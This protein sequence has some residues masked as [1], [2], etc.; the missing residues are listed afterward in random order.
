MDDFKIEGIKIFVDRGARGIVIIEGRQGVVS[1]E[2]IC[3]TCH[4]GSVLDSRSLAWQEGGHPVYVKP[5]DKVHIPKSFPL[6]KYGR[7]FC[8]TCHSAH[9]VDWGKTKQE[10]KLQRTIFLR[11]ENPNSFICR[12]CHRDKVKGNK[13]EK[14]HNHPVDVTSLEIPK[15]IE[16]LGGKVGFKKNQV[17]CE[18]CHKVHGAKGGYK[19]LIKSV[20]NA[21]LCGVCHKDRDVHSMKEAAEKHTHPVN[22]K[23]I[24]ARI[25]ETFQKNGA[26]V[27]RKGEIICLSCH[28]LHNNSANKLL[29]KSNKASSLC[30]ECHPAQKN[31]ILKTKHDLTIKAPEEKNALGQTPAQSGPCG[32]CHLVHKGYAA[33]MWARKPSNDQDAIEK[34]CKSCH[35]KGKVAQKKLTGKISHPV[36]VSI[37]KVDGE[38]DLPLYDAE[39]GA[40]TFN[41]RKGSVTCASCHNTHQWDP[42]QPNNTRDLTEL[43]GNHSNSFLRKRND[44]GTPICYECHIDKSLIEGTDH[45]MMMMAAKHPR[46]HCVQILGMS[47]K[48]EMI[49][50]PAKEVHKLMGKEKGMAT[51]ICGTCHTPHN[52]VYYRL[53]NRE[54]GP[55]ENSGDKLCFTCHAKGRVAEVKLLGEYTHP[56]GVDINRL[57]IEPTTKLPL[58]DDKLNRKS[59]KEGGKVMCTSCHNPHQWDAKVKKKGPGVKVEGDT[60]NSFTRISAQDDKFALCYDCHYDKALIVGTKHDMNVTAPREKNYRNQTVSQSGVC[61]ACHNVHNAIAPWRL[62]NRSLGPGEDNMSKLCNSCHADGRVGQKKQ[63]GQYSHPVGISILGAKADGNI[64]FPTYKDNLYK[65]PKAK[66]MCSSCHDPH[67]WDPGK[68]EKGDFK[69]EEGGFNNSFLR[70]RNENGYGLCIQC[71]EGKDT[72]VETEHDLSVSVPDATNA[73]GDTVAQKGPC[74]QCHRVHNTLEQTR[75]WS[76]PL[77]PGED[78]ISRMCQSC[79][80]DGRVAQK[81]QVGENSHPIMADMRKADGYTSWPLFNIKG[82]RDPNGLVACASCH[83]PHQ[84][85]PSIAKRGPGVNTEGDMNNSFLRKANI[86]SPDFCEEC[87]KEKALVYQTDHDMSITAPESKNLLGQTVAQSGVCSAC[88]VP[89]NAPNKARIFSRAFGPPFIKN[90]NRELGEEVDRGVQYCTSCHSP[91]NPAE[92]KQP[93]VGLHPYGILVGIKNTAWT[94]AKSGFE[95]FR[96]VYKTLTRDLTVK[97]FQIG[98]FRPMYPAYDNNGMIT[99]SGDLVCPTCHNPHVW[100]GDKFERGPGKNVEGWVNN[101]FL[102]TRLLY[103]FCTDCHSYDA[104]YRMKYYHHPRSREKLDPNTI[105]EEMRKRKYLKELQSTE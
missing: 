16:Q 70:A 104:I 31:A 78:G 3:Y 49:Q 45:D 101:S 53:W 44:I 75:L 105:F 59:A 79:H 93:L 22:V 67:R 21:E 50:L 83:D 98:N 88:H 68:K 8:G 13:R 77:G 39:T 66:V 20:E 60:G 62:W 28:K 55:G 57:G 35:E 87:H 38:T 7:I 40:R 63:S 72:L 85:D 30:F 23:P 5:S 100:D 17:I 25:P 12:Q 41:K 37:S 103:D 14:G 91:G 84:W 97:G 29:V 102:R 24:T 99:P 27:G 64:P 71:H 96:Y 10:Q 33:K 86:P 15:E 46:S 74:W 54:L 48:H 76:R 18:S 51:G 26:K 81:K 61:F 47:G 11:F 34:L 92:N 89:H 43:E 82:K 52:A 65:T 19:M 1:T 32:V 2:E 56:T 9:G 95:P 36:G 94:E 73:F 6:D 90:F 42:E 80:S 58:Y 69:A 4:D